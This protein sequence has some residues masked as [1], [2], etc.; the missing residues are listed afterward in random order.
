MR[1]QPH[2][3]LALPTSS[4]RGRFAA[5]ESDAEEGLLRF[6][7]DSASCESVAWVPAEIADM[8]F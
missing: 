1:R 7:I 2:T 5:D 8:F 4:V 3:K 6:P